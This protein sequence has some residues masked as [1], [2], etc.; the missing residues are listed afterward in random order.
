MRLIISVYIEMNDVRKTRDELVCGAYQSPDVKVVVYRSEGVLCASV[1]GSEH[2]DF[3][4]GDS[5]DL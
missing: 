4:Y 1:T 3:T 2:E 5:F